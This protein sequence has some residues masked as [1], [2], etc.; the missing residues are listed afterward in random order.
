MGVISFGDTR[1]VWGSSASVMRSLDQAIALVGPKNYL[2][3]FR[4]LMEWGYN[5]L[6]MEELH[7][8]E[9][10]EFAATISASRQAFLANTELAVLTRESATALLDD[11]TDKL[12]DYIAARIDTDKR[13][14]ERDLWTLKSLAD[15]RDPSK[16]RL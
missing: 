14:V 9:L 11:L 5:C 10:E 7:L 12:A 3:H 16:T 1:Q 8:D 2:I 13:E 6:L 4:C 15:D